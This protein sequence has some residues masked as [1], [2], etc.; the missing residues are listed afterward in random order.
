MLFL[1][2]NTFIH[3][4]LADS[5]L[6]LAGDF[7]RSVSF[8][9]FTQS[10][11]FPAW[12]EYGQSSNLLSINQLA[13]YS[14]AIVASYAS[15]ISTSHVYLLYFV[16]FGSIG[17]V[18][19]FKLTEY[20]L[21]KEMKFF[22]PEFPLAAALFYL[23]G[24]FI[25]ETSFHPAIT[26]SFY[27]SPL[28]LYLIIRGVE[29]EKYKYLVL[30][31][32]IFTIVVADLHF[33]IFGFIVFISYIWY[34]IIFRI[35]TQKSSVYRSVIRGAKYS[36]VVIVSGILLNSFWFFPILSSGGQ[37]LNPNV[38][39]Q[40]DPQILY[41]NADILNIFSGKGFFNLKEVYPYTDQEL[42]T[43][44]ILS[45]LL[46]VLALVSLPLFRKNKLLS[47]LSIIFILSI[48]LSAIPRYAPELY[49]WLVFDVPFASA[50]SWAFRAPKFYLFMSL[51]MA[52]MLALTGMKMHEL[53]KSRH[54]LFRVF[55]AAFLVV[56]VVLSAIPNTPMLTGDMGGHH[57]TQVLPTDYAN[58]IRI[59]DE[60]GDYKTIWAPN[61][62]GLRPSWHH[63]IIG[64]TFEEQVSPLGTFSDSKALDNYI[65]PLATGYRF[66][67]GSM[68]HY[69]EINNLTKFLSPLN[70]KYVA[71]HDDVPALN[72]GSTQLQNSLDEEGLSSTNF[73][74]ITLY[75]IPEPAKH[76]SVS[77]ELTIVEG[78][79]GKLDSLL[80]IDDVQSAVVFSDS[81]I[82]NMKDAWQQ[83]NTFV[84]EAKL[85]LLDYLVGQER[86][87]LLPVFSSTD[88]FNPST[89]WSKSYA[90]S[91]SFLNYLVRQG[92]KPPFQSDYGQGIVFTSTSDAVLSIPLSV[93]NS[94]YRLLTKHFESETGGSIEL[95]I[96][97]TTHHIPT[98]SSVNEFVWSDLG[99]ITLSNKIRSLELR[100]VDGLNAVNL[101][102]LVPTFEYERYQRNFESLIDSKNII[103]LLEGEKDFQGLGNSVRSITFSNGGAVILDSTIV[104][105]IDIIKSDV[106]RMT[107][108][109][110]GTFN[111]SIDGREYSSVSANR[112]LFSELEQ[113]RHTIT[114]ENALEDNRATI[115]S[116]ALVSSKEGIELNTSSIIVSSK[117]IDATEYQV[118]VQAFSPH[119]LVF[120]EGFDKGW[121]AEVKTEDGVQRYMTMPLF[122]SIN[123]FVIDI[124]GEYTVTIKYEPQV[125]LV[126]GIGVSIATF[127]FATLYILYPSFNKI[128]P[129][130]HIRFII[131]RAKMLYVRIMRVARR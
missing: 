89:Y 52:P 122:H 94:Q 60:G 2:I 28:V 45:I 102:L 103:Y 82:Q 112:P 114:I 108:Y 40:E 16:I 12:D 39:T 49:N 23:L 83:A 51:A 48:S 59:L 87:I 27:L 96:D 131:D 54:F 57:K 92:I 127:I 130:W 55:P 63:N 123:G 11:L 70:V 93:E 107:L 86:V 109:G 20:L 25:L 46:V 128:Q 65:H 66:P 41:R 19:V 21:S 17:G 95:T 32:I 117:K 29:D 73:G 7:T 74:F 125:I 78:G 111:V 43:L 58:L 77:Q 18:F 91:P 47:F 118:T 110:S 30:S 115:D 67:Y 81:T 34:D 42:A 4:S 99:E 22:R 13:L 37:E 121:T 15:D 69:G 8:A 80:R 120:S 100:N 1:V 9:R 72:S 33:A 71:I 79:L 98:K 84:P 31:S 75:E 76:V 124:V 129:Q 50:Y 85:G 38:M 44:N 68:T 90:T 26:I 105:D 64:P 116:V 104:S 56:I 113:G 10:T 88:H 36:T 62:S 6:L 24:T 101:V 97:G 14:P 3:A 5:G 119:T 126:A 53:I 61:Y 106:Y 35:V